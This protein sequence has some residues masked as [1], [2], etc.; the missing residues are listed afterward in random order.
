MNHKL[1]YFC[2]LK[3]IIRDQVT[4]RLINPPKVKAIKA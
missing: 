2:R 3:P 4:T 1:N